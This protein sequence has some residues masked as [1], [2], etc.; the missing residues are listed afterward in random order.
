[1]IRVWKPVKAGT[2]DMYFPAFEDHQAIG[3]LVTNIED[4]GMP[5]SLE[6]C[7]RICLERNNEQLVLAYKH[8]DR[9]YEDL[10]A[11]EDHL[12]SVKKALGVG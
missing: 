4:V 12:R 3:G 1:M 11:A 6:E 7:I 5:Y 10:K 8:V 9:L 2:K